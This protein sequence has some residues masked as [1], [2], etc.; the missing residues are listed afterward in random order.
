VREVA[1]SN[2]AVPT[3][4][5]FFL[6]RLA[7]LPDPSR[8]LSLTQSSGTKLGTI[9]YGLGVGFASL[10]GVVFTSVLLGVFIAWLFDSN[11]WTGLG[12]YKPWLPII[13]GEYSTVPGVVVGAVVCWKILKSRLRA[14]Q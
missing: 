4:F 1:S 2:L 9:L 11:G 6:S 12:E 13:F 7:A 8:M 3:I 10:M 14:N 5:V